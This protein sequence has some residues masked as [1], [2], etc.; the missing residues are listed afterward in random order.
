MT[1]FSYPCTGHCWQRASPRLRGEGQ[2]P[3]AAFCHTPPPL[4]S[5][6]QAGGRKKK[7][8][9]KIKYFVAT[10]PQLSLHTALLGMCCAVPVPAAQA[11]PAPGRS[12]PQEPPRLCTLHCPQLLMPQAV[13]PVLGGPP[14]ALSSHIMSLPLHCSWGPKRTSEPVAHTG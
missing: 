7:I 11:V 4:G 6:S 12:S 13:G 3:P 1:R 10:F 5:T 14:A 2:S 9:K 8:K